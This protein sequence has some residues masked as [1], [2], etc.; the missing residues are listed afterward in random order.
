MRGGFVNLTHVNAKRLDIVWD[1]EDL[2]SLLCNRVEVAKISSTQSM[3]A[4]ELTMTVLRSFS[5]T[6]GCGSAETDYVGVDDVAHTRWKW[7]LTPRNLID[8]AKKAQENQL[9]AEDRQPKEYDPN[10]SV[11]ESDSVRKALHRL[12]EDR[13][14]DT[15]LAEAA[16][17]ASL[18]ETFRKKAEHNLKTLSDLLKEDEGGVKARIKPLIEMGFLEEIGKPTRCRCS[19]R[20]SWHHAGQ[21]L[22]T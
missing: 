9:R 6:S 21:S 13:V 10:A 16:D 14:N 12:S 4:T 11:V 5:S 1:E 20:R 8:L 17:Y 18:I 2:K 15:L 3:Q 19:T 22:C 7:D